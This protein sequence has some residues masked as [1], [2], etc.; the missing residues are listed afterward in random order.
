MLSWIVRIAFALAAPITALLVSRDALNF[1]PVQTMIAV[2][3]ILAP[4]GV[5]AVWPLL[6]DRARRPEI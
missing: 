5:V 3:L 6:A 1:G 4:V 2:I